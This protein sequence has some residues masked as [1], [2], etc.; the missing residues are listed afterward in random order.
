MGNE[1][2]HLP[3]EEASRHILVGEA[4]ESD[5]DKT[6]FSA[7]DFVMFA[8]GALT[9]TPLCDAG[10]N[11]VV[12]GEHVQR[13]LG[14]ILAGLILG[15]VAASFHWWKDRT[16]RG[17]RITAFVLLP[18]LIVL[19]I[20]YF[21]WRPTV[22][23][24]IFGNPRPT[25]QGRIASG[26]PH[27]LQPPAHS[28]QPTKPPQPLAFSHTTHRRMSKPS[29]DRHSPTEAATPAP[30]PVPSAPPAAPSTAPPRQKTAT[31]RYEF[32]MAEVDGWRS[33]LD[34]FNH[35]MPSYLKFC[36][37]FENFMN[38][39]DGRQI[40]SPLDSG[41]LHIY[42]EF[43]INLGNAEVTLMSSVK[44]DFGQV[45][46]LEDHPNYDE[47]KFLPTPKVED[48]PKE[49]KDRYRRLYDSCKT[50]ASKVNQ[51]H[52]QYAGQVE[53]DEQIIR[54]YNKPH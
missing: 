45:L 3:L 9:A 52:A 7:V 51:W 49:W 2:K 33:K 53:S 4:A 21:A 15:I 27:A 8:V 25:S 28:E 35:S 36:M 16:T 14:A 34:S 40:A 38:G 26:V 18:I 31:E 47:D 39:S 41:D 29:L 48:V 10:W 32:A 6:S 22:K 17:A 54:D 46:N 20:A 44:N 23:S 37:D 13:G 5:L 50:G 42:N 43:E 24:Q 11:A 19:A 30:I 1:Q 12:S